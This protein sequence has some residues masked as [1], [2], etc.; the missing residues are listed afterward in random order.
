MSQDLSLGEISSLS[1]S[2][3]HIGLRVGF[4]FAAVVENTFPPSWVT[5]YTQEA[6]FLDDPVVRWVHTHT[7]ITAWEDLFENDPR[8]ILRLAAHYGMRHGL[9]VSVLDEDDATGTRSYGMFARKDRAFTES[10]GLALLAYIDLRHGQLSPPGNITDREIE[11]L[12]RVSQ[13]QRLKVIS[14]DLG[15]TEG[16]IKQRLKLAKNKLGAKTTTEAVAMARERGLI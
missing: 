5:L 15:V 9:A 14:Y 6:F 4:S 7:G 13:G 2:G 1:P 3:Y 8:G 11:V 16:A 10:E 12:V